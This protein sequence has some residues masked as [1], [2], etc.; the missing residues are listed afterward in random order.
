M[1]SAMPCWLLDTT[2]TVALKMYWFNLESPSDYFKFVELAVW[3][4]LFQSILHISGCTLRP[5]Q[6][7]I[8]ERFFFIDNQSYKHDS[9]I[10]HLFSHS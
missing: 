9:D 6:P 7:D 10:L 5:T 3:K 8:A 1:L 2:Y 4:Q